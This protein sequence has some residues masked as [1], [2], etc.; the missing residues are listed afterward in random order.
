MHSLWECLVDLVRGKS[1]MSGDTELSDLINEALPDSPA[2]YYLKIKSTGG[3]P[4]GG[5]LI[6]RYIRSRMSIVYLYNW[7]YAVRI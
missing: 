7:P 3:I 6:Y 2:C 5:G 1:P 4:G